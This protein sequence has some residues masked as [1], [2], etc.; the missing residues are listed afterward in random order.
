MELK[1]EKIEDMQSNL[2]LIVEKTKEIMKNKG[3]LR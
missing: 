1:S 3:L 2:D